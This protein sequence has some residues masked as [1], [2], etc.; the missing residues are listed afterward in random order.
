MEGIN[1]KIQRQ[2]AA[3]K[4]NCKVKG[5]GI[6]I[7]TTEDI[8][9]KVRTQI[10]EEHISFGIHKELDLSFGIH[11]KVDLSFGIQKEVD[12]NFR[13]LKEV[14]LS[15][16]IRKEGQTDFVNRKEEHNWIYFKDKS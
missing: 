13:I 7:D 1:F 2:E 15:F 6:K 10:E 16:G 12:L 9:M 11:K 4:V 3:G 5:V 14:D 8:H